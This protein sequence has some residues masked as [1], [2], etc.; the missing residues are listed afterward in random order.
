MWQAISRLQ[1][2]GLKYSAWNTL[3]EESR[4]P[5]MLA[6]GSVRR[7]KVQAV[8]LD[9]FAYERELVPDFIKIDAENFEHAVVAGLAGILDHAQPVVLLESGSESALAAG[10]EFAARGYRIM[11]SDGPGSLHAWDGVLADANARYKD[12]LFVPAPRLAAFAVGDVAIEQ[13]ALCR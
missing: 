5:G 11:V 2:S 13:A 3:A 10:R 4:M 8:R 1:T 6:A 12:L 9:V 7:V